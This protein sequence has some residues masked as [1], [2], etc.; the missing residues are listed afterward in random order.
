ML[1]YSFR[2]SIMINSITQESQYISDPTP[3]KSKSS[4]LYICWNMQDWFLYFAYLL[5]R[6]G[7]N[8][9]IFIFMEFSITGAK[10]IQRSAEWPNSSRINV[11]FLLKP[12]LTVSKI[13]SQV[14]VLTNK[15][16][17]I[18]LNLSIYIYW[19]VLR[20]MFET[21]SCILQ[22]SCIYLAT[23]LQLTSILEL[24]RNYP[25]LFTIYIQ[26]CSYLAPI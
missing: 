24:F 20:L 3:T 5:L 8:K 17:A 2:Q 13:S 9:K 4:W 21:L 1:M 23:I 25:D 19:I 16:V 12:S 15:E 7:F 26:S 14:I 10:K 6:E 18:L 22:L 11:C